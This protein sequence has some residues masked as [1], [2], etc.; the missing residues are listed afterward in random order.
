MNKVLF[1]SY[2]F[3]PAGGGSVVRSYTFVKYLPSTG[4]SPFVL[5]VKEKYYPSFN[6]DE[7]LL[8]ALDTTH[9]KMIRT[10]SFGPKGAV[11]DTFQA[12]I[13]GLDGSSSFF[14]KNIKPA[15][16]W[17]Y[18][19]FMIPDEQVLWAPHAIREGRH[20]IKQHHIDAIFAT[21]PPHSA[22]IIGAALSRLTHIPFI[23]D[24]RDDWI[25][26]P[27]F[28]N[29]AWHKRF[30]SRLLEKWVIKTAA[31]V[32]TVTAESS[33]LFQ[34]KYAGQPADKFQVISNGFDAQDF[35]EMSGDRSGHC[36]D[37][38]RI[39]YTGGLPI[40]RSPV[41]LFKALRELAAEL[42][43]EEL[44]QIDF[45]GNTHQEFIDVVQQLGIGNVV[46]FHKFVSR[47]ESLQQ[48]VLSDSG[49]MIIPEE[50]GSQTAIPGKIYEY[51]GARKFVLALCPPQSAPARL[52]RALNLGIVAPPGDVEAIKTALREMFSRF[53]NDGL[54]MDLPSNILKKYERFTQTECLA[55]IFKQVGTQ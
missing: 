36:K 8:Q 20:L 2:Y 7:T 4:I 46:K 21:T 51:L 53:K 37:R 47:K 33:T 31:K 52:V 49:L 10:A 16:R 13:Y 12:R 3:P 32:I 1:I 39:I 45:Y 23:M 50:E 54:S 24:V 17:L 41:A 11:F 15:L 40:K 9:V 44:L 35:S 55:E 42:P 22:G 30:I 5:T 48:L 29:G 14:Q 6:K 27:L 38:L 18:H 28:D 26:N 34:K 43:I 25:G 19:I